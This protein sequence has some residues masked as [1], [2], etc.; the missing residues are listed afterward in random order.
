MEK[1]MDYAY[2]IAEVKEKKEAAAKAQEAAPDASA[3]GA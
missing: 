3:P 1:M 2:N